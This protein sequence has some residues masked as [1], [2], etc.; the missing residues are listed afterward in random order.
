MS[1]APAIRAICS[2]R[3]ANDTHKPLCMRLD[4]YMA[5]DR[6]MPWALNRDNTVLLETLRLDRIEP[7]IQESIVADYA[8]RFVRIHINSHPPISVKKDSFLSGNREL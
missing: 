3:S 6:M 4:I 1:P 7:R 5:I 2:C 8:T